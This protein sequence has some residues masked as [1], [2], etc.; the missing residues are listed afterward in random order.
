M[1]IEADR[2][3][4]KGGCGSVNEDGESMK[5]KATAEF[6]SAEKEWMDTVAVNYI[7]GQADGFQ[8]GY[9]QAIADFNENIL[10][11][12]QGSDDKPQQSVLDTLVDLGV[13]L[14][15]RRGIAE[16][17]K[18]EAINNGYESYYNWTFKNKDKSITYVNLYTKAEEET[19]EDEECEQ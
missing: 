16:R 2:R 15:R 19:N 6:T 18:S 12:W 8:L 5:H 9:A 10:D 11:Y 3:F 4:Q 17:N 14:G 13:E 7:I 1:D